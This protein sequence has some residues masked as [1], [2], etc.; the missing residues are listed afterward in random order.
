M[1]NGLYVDDIKE[2]FFDIEDEGYSVEV[3]LV[4]VF[5]NKATQNKT[6]PRIFEFELRPQVQVII[7]KGTNALQYAQMLNDAESLFNSDLFKE[8][9][10]VVK[11]RLAEYNLEVSEINKLFSGI[12]IVISEINI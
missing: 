5:V 8:V 3:K 7:R 9:I 4:N 2:M 11:S 12:K 1:I 10:E 6:G